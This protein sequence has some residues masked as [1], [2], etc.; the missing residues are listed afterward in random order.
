MTW[1]A[2]DRRDRLVWFHRSEIPHWSCACGWSWPC[3]PH[4]PRKAAFEHAA[5]CPVVAN[6][7]RFA[8]IRARRETVEFATGGIIKNEDARTVSER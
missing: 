2:P 3:N 5:R 6:R 1:P 7:R 8:A 4:E